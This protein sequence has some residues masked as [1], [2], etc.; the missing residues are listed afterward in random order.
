LPSWGRPVQKR[1]SGHPGLVGRGFPSPR[2]LRHLPDAGPVMPKALTATGP[3]PC[4]TCHCDPLSESRDRVPSSHATPQSGRRKH[5]PGP[6]VRSLARIRPASAGPVLTPPLRGR[7]LLKRPGPSRP[8]S[9]SVRHSRTVRMSN[10]ASAT[11]APTH[12]TVIRAPSAMTIGI[13]SGGRASAERVSGTAASGVGPRSTVSV[14]GNWPL[15]CGGLGSRV[16]T[17]PTPK[18]HRDTQ[19][20]ERHRALDQ[21]HVGHGEGQNP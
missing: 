1:R 9:R 21:L 18:S 19:M 6:T 12:A 13:E 8:R 4:R 2:R 20:G 11:S 10:Q 17:H 16:E 3:T 5:R 7:R 14:G 15:P